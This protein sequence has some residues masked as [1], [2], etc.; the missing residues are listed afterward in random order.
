MNYGDGLYGGMFV[1]GMYAAAFF[2]TDPRKAV[3]AGLKSIPA[4]SGYAKLVSD[5][6]A[7]HKQ[8]PDD[9]KKAWRMLKDKWDR[10]DPC[11]EGAMK[12]FN[13]YA[14]LN[15][16]HIVLGLLWGKGD[17]DKTLDISTRAGQD[18]D[19][20]PLRSVARV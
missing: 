7:W 19:C 13:I 11:P 12:D 5:L 3:E 1:S 18:S 2:E 15:G 14:R 20:N 8:Y 17:F 10:D 6:L 9:W 4:R 16:S